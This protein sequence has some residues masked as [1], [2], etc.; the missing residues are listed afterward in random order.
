MYVECFI[1]LGSNLADPQSQVTTAIEELA[2][3]S[4]SRLVG[5]SSLYRSDPMGP[6]DQPDYIN[7]VARLETKLE[8][9]ALLDELQAIEQAHGRVREGERWGPRTLD[10][11]LLLYGQEQIHDDRLDVPHVGMGERNFVL[12]PLAE[13]VTEDML[14]PDLGSLANLLRDCSAEGLEKVS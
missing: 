1:G 11:D 6:T 7:A 12:Y 5:V 13:L 9:M 3:L 14:I 10:L 8:P 2:Q 4:E